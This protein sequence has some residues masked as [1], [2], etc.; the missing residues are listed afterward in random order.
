MRRFIR[1]EELLG[2]LAE[3]GFVINEVVEEGGL[4]IHDGDNPVVIRIIAR[5][6]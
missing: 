5:K 4:A 3:A 2:E 1:K 6:T